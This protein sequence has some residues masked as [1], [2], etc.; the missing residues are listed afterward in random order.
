MKRSHCYDPAFV[1]RFRIDYF[2]PRKM[3]LLGRAP[4]SCCN[5][6]LFRRDGN[7]SGHVRMR[8][9]REEFWDLEDIGGYREDDRR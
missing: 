6:Y 9:P 2:F 1:Y 8:G 3:S 7:P 4:R 5:A